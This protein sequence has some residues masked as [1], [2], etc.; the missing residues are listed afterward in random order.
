MPLLLWLL[1]TFR[2]FWQSVRSLELDGSVAEKTAPKLPLYLD[3][4]PSL[5]PSLSSFL[6]LSLRPSTPSLPPF[7]SNLPLLHFMSSS[8]ICLWLSLCLSVTFIYSLAPCH[9]LYVS[10]LDH[11][12]YPPW[13]PCGPKALSTVPLMTLLGVASRRWVVVLLIPK[14][15]AQRFLRNK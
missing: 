12:Q 4:R 15:R 5:L 6:S 1:H 8:H 10:F 2:P 14:K 13:C 11:V 9:H 7:L 3:N